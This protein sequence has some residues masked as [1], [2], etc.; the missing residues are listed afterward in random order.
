MISVV[1]PM[2]I[3][4]MVTKPNDLKIESDFDGLRSRYA[5]FSAIK[6]LS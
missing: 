4:N 6:F 5:N 3:P 2:Q 1:T